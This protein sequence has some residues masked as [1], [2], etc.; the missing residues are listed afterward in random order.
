MTKMYFVYILECFD[1]SYYVGC[2]NDVQIR[3]ER[4]NNSEA[5]EWTKTR[6]PVKLVY[7][8]P[9]ETLQLARSRETQLKGWTRKK[10]EN[11]INGIWSKI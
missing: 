6:R 11:L 7:H 4:H 9:H 3:A 2:T 8:E 10:K 1:G 5:A